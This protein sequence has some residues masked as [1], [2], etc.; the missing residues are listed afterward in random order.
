MALVKYSFSIILRLMRDSTVWQGLD[1]C[2]EEILNT[3]LLVS[4]HHNCD[5]SANMAV[6]DLSKKYQ[7]K[8]AYSLGKVSG[9]III[10]YL[11]A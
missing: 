4:L 1:A 3:K 5:E 8:E 7:I 6:F 9:G 2:E 11:Y 10:F